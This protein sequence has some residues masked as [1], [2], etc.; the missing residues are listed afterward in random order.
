M[1]KPFGP[2]YDFLF[3]QEPTL[4]DHTHARIVFRDEKKI[5]ER[6]LMNDMKFV[7]K[8]VKQNDWKI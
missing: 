7:S 4:K 1:V 3:R 2:K 5:Q 6:Q 8:W